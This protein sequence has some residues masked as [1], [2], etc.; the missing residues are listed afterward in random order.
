MAERRQP[1]GDRGSRSKRGGPSD[2]GLLEV[3]LAV[4]DQRMEE[5]RAI[6]K[7]P[8]QRALANA[9]FARDPI[10]RDPVWTIALEQPMGCLEQSFAVARG[11]GALAARTLHERQVGHWQAVRS[12]RLCADWG[13]WHRRSI[14]G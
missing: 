3:A 5:A 13:P 12:A 1:V 14:W 6:P 2:E 10:H 4:V 11:V 7:A 8:E 9:C